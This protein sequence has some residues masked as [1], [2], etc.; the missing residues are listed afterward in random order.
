MK[1]DQ[2]IASISVS[3]DIPISKYML[4][5]YYKVTDDNIK[6]FDIHAMIRLLL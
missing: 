1:V 2:C 6:G 3:P 4:L 5:D